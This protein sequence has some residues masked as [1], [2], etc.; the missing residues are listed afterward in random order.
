MVNNAKLTIE[1]ESGNLKT[2][3]KEGKPSLQIILTHSH[4]IP[5]VL[6]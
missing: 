6:L 3:E 1:V 4:R 2:A 5:W